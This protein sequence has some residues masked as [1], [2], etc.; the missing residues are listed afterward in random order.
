VNGRN[1]FIT[2][3]GHSGAVLA[4]TWSPDGK[5][6]A[7]GSVDK[8]VQVWSAVNGGNVFTYKGHSDWVMAVAWSPDGKRLVPRL[9]TYDERTQAYKGRG[10]VIGHVIGRLITLIYALLRKDY[11]TLSG[12]GPGAEPPEPVLYDAQLHKQHR[13]GHYQPLKK[14]PLEN[15]IVQVQL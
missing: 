5:H 2:Y 10:K 12:L 15:R 14:K 3:Q 8:T 9:C 4:V 1:A 7:S 13:T 11:E 6:I